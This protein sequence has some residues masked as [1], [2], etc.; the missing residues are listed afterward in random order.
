M[1]KSIQNIVEARFHNEFNNNEQ[2]RQDVWDLFSLIRTLALERKIWDSAISKII[3]SDDFL[4]DVQMQADIWNISL[5]GKHERGSSPFSKFFRNPKRKKDE[6]FLF[7]PVIPINESNVRFYLYL[8]LGQISSI[9]ARKIIPKHVTLKESTDSLNDFI[10]SACI[11]WCKTNYA[12]SMTR[13]IIDS[14]NLVEHHSILNAF[15]RKLKRILY[16]YNSEAESDGSLWEFWKHYSKSV[17][18]LF[19]D[20]LRN[21]EGSKEYELEEDEEISALIY[22][23]VHRINLLT[24]RCLTEQI[25]DTESVKYAV[26]D[27]SNY[28][29]IKLE[30]IKDFEGLS[31]ILSKNP[32]DYFVDIVDTEPRIVCFLDILGFS[33]LVNSYDEDLSSTVLQDIHESFS[34]AK[35]YLLDDT[36][37]IQDKEL[38][39]H[40]KYQSFSDNICISIPY[41][42]NETD[43]KLNLGLLL[44]YVRSFQYLMMIKKFYVRG[45]ISL[46]SFYSNESII[47][48]KGLV[49]AYQLESQKAIYPRIII[50]P[51][52]IHKLNSI[53][54]PLS[55]GDNLYKS[56]VFDWENSAFVNPFGLIEHNSSD[57]TSSLDETNPYDLSAFRFKAGFKIIMTEIVNSYIGEGHSELDIIKEDILQNIYRYNGFGNIATKYIWLLEFIKWWEDDKS[58]S[59]RFSYF[60]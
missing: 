8:V 11:E 29:N 6:F 33:D 1:R 28:F 49:K 57:N 26:V 39:R 41:F 22:E 18:K 58:G 59:L 13:G 7:F 43:F 48:S 54:V 32:K 42:D 30:S 15:K 40:L 51:E 9:S 24:D 44:R 25:F 34:L 2:N 27:F 3:V 36:L 14:S 12:E 55:D 45:G 20:I 23:V 5:G 31:I 19:I 10:H 35:K 52:I 16:K 37:N 17:E 21:A 60:N 38:I 50:D 46:G 53:S 47:F 4:K 56:I